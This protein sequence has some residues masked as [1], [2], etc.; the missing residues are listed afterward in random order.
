MSSEKTNKFRENSPI[1]SIEENDISSA[2]KND[3]EDY[4]KKPNE[5]KI[6]SKSA[7]KVSDKA[8]KL[9]NKISF[10]ATHKEVNDYVTNENVGLTYLLK[11]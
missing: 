7:P 1:V 6:K 5:K 8:A 3:I 9:E 2:H 10:L 11:L 4:E